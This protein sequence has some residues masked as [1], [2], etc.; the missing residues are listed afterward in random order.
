MR[1]PRLFLLLSVVLILS[2]AHAF[3][4]LEKIL[5]RIA[6]A[7]LNSDARDTTPDSLQALCVSVFYF[8]KMLTNFFKDNSDD[9]R[10]NAF[11]KRVQSSNV[12]SVAKQSIN[13]FNGL[14]L[15]NIRNEFQKTFNFFKRNPMP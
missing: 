1:T 7:H 4:E 11:L 13:D 10:V 12:Y 6:D 9:S 3:D 14:F 5:T 15:F 8:K 2:F